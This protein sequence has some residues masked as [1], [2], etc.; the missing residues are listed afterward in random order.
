LRQLRGDALEQQTMDPSARV[1][2]GAMKHPMSDRLRGVVPEASFGI[3]LATDDER[4]LRAAADELDRLHAEVERLRAEISECALENDALTFINNAC[5]GDI[6]RAWMT[7]WD[8]E[9]R[10]QEAQ[11]C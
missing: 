10:A 6:F 11:R 9:W 1:E 8:A 4:T 3:D 2:G 5:R 7:A